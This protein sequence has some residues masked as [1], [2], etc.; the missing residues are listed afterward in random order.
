[1]DLQ[2][3]Q[4]VWDLMIF[5]KSDLETLHGQ[6]DLSFVFNWN[7]FEMGLLN[8][9]INFYLLRTFVLILV[10]CVVSS[11]TTF[12]PNFTKTTKMRTKVR[13]K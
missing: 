4:F 13:N 8:L 9:R 5:L 2:E 3:L 1:M 10:V 6:P 12:R 7:H 11:F